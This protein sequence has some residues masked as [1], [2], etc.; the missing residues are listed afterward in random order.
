MVVCDLKLL[1][2]RAEHTDMMV[3]CFQG[4]KNR[5]ATQSDTK[6]RLGIQETII[7][8]MGTN[9]LRSNRN[10]DFLGGELFALVPTPKRKFRTAHLS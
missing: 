10:L 8:H 7:I 1:K 3:E 9:D 4:I 2:F 6:G 5:A